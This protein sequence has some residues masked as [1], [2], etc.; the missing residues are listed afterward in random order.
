MKQLF[1]LATLTAIAVFLSA[2]TLYQ[3]PSGGHYT[4]VPGHSYAHDAEEDEPV[5]APNG[6]LRPF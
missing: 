2:C 6:I 5:I 1:T 3:S 4:L